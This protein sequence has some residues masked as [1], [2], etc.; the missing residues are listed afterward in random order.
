MTEDRNFIHV[1]TSDITSRITKRLREFAFKP[2]EPSSQDICNLLRDSV[3]DYVA[4]A[5]MCK[6]L[7]FHGDDEKWIPFAV[8]YAAAAENDDEINKLI[9]LLRTSPVTNVY[10][11]DTGGDKND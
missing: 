6:F 10:G 8:D 2:G 7:I 11:Y 9:D 4:G 5:I 3:A 1:Q